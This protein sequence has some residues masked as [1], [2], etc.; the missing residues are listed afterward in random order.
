MPSTTTT[1]HHNTPRHTDEIKAIITDVP[2][3]IVRWGITLFGGILLMIFGLS[4]FIPYPDTVKTSLKIKSFN[5]PEPVVP[6]VSGRLAKLLVTENE[7]I[8]CGQVLGYIESNTNRA[9]AIDLLINLREM[10]PRVEFNQHFAVSVFP[11]TRYKELGGL[12]APYRDFSR[13]YSIYQSLE[14][15]KV[16]DR[17]AGKNRMQ[18]EEITHAKL[19]FLRSLNKLIRLIEDWKS[20]YILTA[21]VAGKLI[22]AD[23]NQ[24]NDLITL[25]QPVFYIQ[26]DNESFFGEIVIPQNKLMKIK[27]GQEVIMKLKT[28]PFQ[29]YGV[30]KGRMSYIPE[31]SYKDSIF[32][33][34]VDFNQAKTLFAKKAIHLEEGMVAEAEIIT[35]NTTF[36]E[37]IIN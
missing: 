15:N 26:Q 20:Q 10:L 4:A 32:V 35:K 30:I 23:I 14:T 29:E 11:K 6:K 27:I 22:Y 3:W 25:N 17:N 9:E 31:L 33:A 21:P 5:A 24:G 37:R 18:N 28:Y 1:Q 36:L 13:R 19:S 12:Q 2:S 7:R 16:K 34:R 8:N